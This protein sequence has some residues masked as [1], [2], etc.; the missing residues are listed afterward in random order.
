MKTQKE[1]LL[2][3]QKILEKK[4]LKNMEKYNGKFKK[5]TMYFTSVHPNIIEYGLL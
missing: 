1:D 2:A 5:N 4:P 3:I